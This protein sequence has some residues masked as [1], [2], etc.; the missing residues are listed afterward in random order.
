MIIILLINPDQELSVLAHL[1]IAEYKHLQV[2]LVIKK[3]L[4]IG[5]GNS[6]MRAR[7]YEVKRYDSTTTINECQT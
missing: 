5:L 7:H 1:A 4:I 6:T 3:K 2:T